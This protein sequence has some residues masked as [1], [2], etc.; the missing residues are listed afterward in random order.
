MVYYMSEYD[1]GEGGGGGARLYDECGQLYD[2]YH[3]VCLSRFHLPA[4]V[5]LPVRTGS[6]E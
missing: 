6:Y 2:G 4:Q 3:L 5:P 1:S